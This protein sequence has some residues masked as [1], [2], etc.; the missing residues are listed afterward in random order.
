MRDSYYAYVEDEVV[1]TELIASSRK[2]ALRLAQAE[3]SEA[4]D[5]ANALG[6]DLAGKI[7]SL[8]EEVQDLNAELKADFEKLKLL[9][10]NLNSPTEGLKKAEDTFLEFFYAIP[11][12]SP[13]GEISKKKKKDIFSRVKYEEGFKDHGDGV[14]VFDFV[15]TISY[16]EMMRR[17]ANA[18]IT[19]LA[20][21]I[22][23]NE[24]PYLEEIV[25]LHKDVRENKEGFENER[26]KILRKYASRLSGELDDLCEDMHGVRINDSSYVAGSILRFLQG[27]SHDDGFE[28][29]EDLLFVDYDFI[30]QTLDFLVVNQWISVLDQGK[31]RLFYKAK[32]EEL[33]FVDSGEE[34]GVESSRSQHEGVSRVVDEAAGEVVQDIDELSRIDEKLANAGYTPG[35]VH[36]YMKGLRGFIG[37]HKIPGWAVKKNTSR[38]LSKIDLR[39]FDGHLKTFVNDGLILQ[40]GKNGYSLNPSVSAVDENLR[41]I[42]GYYLSKKAIGSKQE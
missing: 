35:V 12:N 38:Y 7:N 27:V 19:E 21:L 17:V 3:I 8:E 22:K 13:L 29:D 26:K 41:G 23:E 16:S 20:K 4:R 42:L 28:M 24:K 9:Y 33:D 30:N 25:G 5:M 32:L 2:D 14:L 37:S 34:R 1:A 10:T 39:Y 31:F 6:T 40:H 18:M 15:P 11:E 36:A